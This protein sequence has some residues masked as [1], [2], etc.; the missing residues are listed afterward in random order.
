[1]KNAILVTLVVFSMAVNAGGIYKWVDENGV[2]HF[3]ERKPDNVES[4]QIVAKE[5]NAG[6]IQIR[7]MTGGGVDIETITNKG[8]IESIMAHLTAEAGQT[9]SDTFYQD[10]LLFVTMQSGA[11]SSYSIYQDGGVYFTPKLGTGRVTKK[12]QVKDI[13]GLRGVLP[14]E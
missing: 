8:E 4:E 14:K 13:V 5:D 1:M 12:Y 7:V 6:V 3:G 11:Q 9:E 2:T 10:Y